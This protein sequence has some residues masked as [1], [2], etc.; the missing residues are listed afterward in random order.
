MERRQKTVETSPVA[1]HVNYRF[2]L[3]G[4]PVLGPGAKIQVT[5]GD[6]GKVVE[7]YKF[8]RLP[9]AERELDLLPPEAALELLRRDPAFADLREGEARV[10]FHRARLAH[11]A[12]PP[13]ESQGCLIPVYAFDGTVST[14]QLERYDFVRY[15]VGVR[16]TAEDAKQVGA[17]F[18]SSSPLFS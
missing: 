3:D 5:Y 13:R 18:R 17:V 15:V 11:Y 7:F 1:L 9:K 4:L 10:V 2:S 12:L 16:F 8:W 14:A 6:R